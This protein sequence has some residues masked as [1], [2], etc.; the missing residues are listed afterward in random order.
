MQM[1][2]PV[3]LS[4][5]HLIK[6]RPVKIVLVSFN[7]GSGWGVWLTDAVFIF[8]MLAGAWP[9]LIDDFVEHMYRFGFF[10]AK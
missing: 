6:L 10:M 9:V 4:P 5:C 2:V 1:L 7:N 3:Y 8:L